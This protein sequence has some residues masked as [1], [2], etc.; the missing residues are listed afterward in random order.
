MLRTSLRIGA[1]LVTALF[2]TAPTAL[3]AQ[4]IFSATAASPI[5]GCVGYA[6]LT[7]AQWWGSIAGN[8]L[9]LN[10]RNVSGG[11]PASNPNSVITEVGL[12]NILTT[13][14]ITSFSYSGPGDWSLNQEVNGY[15]VLGEDSFGADARGTDGIHVGQTTMFTFV[16]SQSFAASQFADA[17]IAFHDQGAIASCGASSKSVFDANTGALQTGRGSQA[18]SC[19][20][21]GGGQSGIVPEPS[22]YLLLGTGMLGLVGV[23]RRRR[24][25]QG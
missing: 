4:A 14:D 15:N 20:P 25:P 24:Q 12:G 13:Y 19:I 6:F 1:A 8:T 21:G 17:E 23:A 22:T 9:T 11:A 10:V 5:S 16:A 2:A 3:E 18:S 7:C